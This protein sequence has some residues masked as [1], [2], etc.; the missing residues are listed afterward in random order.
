MWLAVAS[1]GSSRADAAAL[2]LDVAPLGTYSIKRNERTLAGQSVSW[3]QPRW[4]FTH[5][6]SVVLETLH[7]EVRAGSHAPRR[8]GVDSR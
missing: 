5:V 4:V 1:E 6:A 8:C 2:A 3:L 7:H